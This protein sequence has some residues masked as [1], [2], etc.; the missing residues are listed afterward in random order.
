MAISSQ[1]KGLWPTGP[2]AIAAATAPV[3]EG[4]L[5]GTRAHIPA[6]TIIDRDFGVR[7]RAALLPVT[8]GNGRVFARHTPSLSPQE[9][10][11]FMNALTRA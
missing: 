10:V 6:V 3:V 9:R 2:Y 11:D 8:L 5:S 1:M 7:H 4:L